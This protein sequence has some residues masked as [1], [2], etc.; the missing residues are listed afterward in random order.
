MWLKKCVGTD[1]F[2]YRVEILGKAVVSCARY[3]GG[4]EDIA[5]SQSIHEN[6]DFEGG[7]HDKLS[8]T[9]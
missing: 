2:H 5:F 8:I 7:V 9:V 4:T 3:A 6:M 1:G